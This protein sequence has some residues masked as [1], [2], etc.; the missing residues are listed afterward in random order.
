MD[1]VMFCANCGAKLRDEH[2]D[3]CP[4]CGY[5][6][7]R[8]AEEKY[9]RKLGAIRDSL[10]N[11]DEEEAR[12]YRSMVSG[13]I[14]RILKL[15]GVIAIVAFLAV[16]GVRGLENKISPERSA[17]EQ[18]EEMLW[19]HEY[20]AK[21]DE[22]YEACQYEQMA[23]ALR[24]EDTKD[25]AVY[26]WEHF[27]FADKYADYM[28]IRDNLEAT[29]DKHG[30]KPEIWRIS[31]NSYRLFK[32]Y[33]KEYEQ[34]TSIT[35]EEIVLLNQ[36]REE[37]IPIIYNRLG[38]TDEEMDSFLDKYNRRK[39]GYLAIGHVEDVLKEYSDR[40]H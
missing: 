14:K 30:G 3:K 27:D 9:M 34:S 15:L 26:N 28:G 8:G 20:F 1:K 38:L 6:I 35:E 22:M 12:Q 16:I 13:N 25:H 36:A 4:Y 10:D 33:Y 23:Q 2:E 18:K 40:M 24:S 7:E 29:M 21:L 31:V 11:V 39:E 17:Q 5:I 37:I 19:Q 32:F